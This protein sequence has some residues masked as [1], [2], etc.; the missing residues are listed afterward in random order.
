MRLRR[1][2]PTACVWRP[3][4]GASPSGLIGSAAHDPICPEPGRVSPEAAKLPRI[5]R[6]PPQQRP[7]RRTQTGR[8]LP[9]IR[10]RAVARLW[11][12]TTSTSRSLRTQA[13]A[14]V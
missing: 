14:V 9:A 3:T 6:R 7:R 11:S 13:E 5:L 10:R 4:Q 2:V 8:E 1:E 12:S